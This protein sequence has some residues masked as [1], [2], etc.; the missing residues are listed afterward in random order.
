[1]FYVYAYSKE[2]SQNFMDFSLFRLLKSYLGK[3]LEYKTYDFCF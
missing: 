1:M 3:H 2:Y